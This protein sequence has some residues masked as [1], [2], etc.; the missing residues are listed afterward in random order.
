NTESDHYDEYLD[1]YRIQTIVKKYSDYIRYPIRMAITKSQVKEGTGTQDKPA[2]YEETTEIETLNSM[3]PIWKKAKKELSEDDYNHFYKTKFNDYE[4]PLLHIHSSI[5]G[6][7]TYHA[8][9]F[10][11]ARAPFDYYTKEYQKGLQ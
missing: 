5:E 3:I 4:D 9:L 11:P 2:E 1:Q 6:A 10:V 7:A 8:L